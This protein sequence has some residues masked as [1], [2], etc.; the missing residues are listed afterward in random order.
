MD[1]TID[2]P[3]DFN[4]KYKDCVGIL[5]DKDGQSDIFLVEYMSGDGD[6]IFG[7]KNNNGVWKTAVHKIDEILLDFPMPPLGLVNHKDVVVDVTRHPKK[8]YRRGFTFRNNVITTELVEEA[9]AFSR[10]S[11]P[12]DQDAALIQDIF[13]PMYHTI[14]DAL[15]LVCSGKRATVAIS[16]RYYLSASTA[17]PYIYLGFG[18]DMI[19]G[20]VNESN[21]MCTVFKSATPLLEDLSSYVTIR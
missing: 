6:A 8:Q 21:G 14:E 12:Y 15:A 16:N 4:L 20:R 1:L 13:D 17:L 2:V 11:N 18:K 19:I 3:D 9:I 10:S 7:F 5:K